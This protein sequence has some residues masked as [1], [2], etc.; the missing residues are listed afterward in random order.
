MSYYYRMLCLGIGSLTDVPCSALWS[1]GADTY[2]TAG[3]EV[4]A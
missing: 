2:D 3:V 1:T 4:P